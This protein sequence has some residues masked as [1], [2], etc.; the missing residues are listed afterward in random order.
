MPNSGRIPKAMERNRAT[1]EEMVNGIGRLL[2]SKAITGDD[3]F[4]VTAV[5]AMESLER[6]EKGEID[7]TAP[8]AIKF[9]EKNWE[10]IPEDVK[11]GF[12]PKESKRQKPKRKTK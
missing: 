12:M 4:L 11:S 3:A 5:Y 10:R 1:F 2:N 7:P 9:L 6:V 8:L